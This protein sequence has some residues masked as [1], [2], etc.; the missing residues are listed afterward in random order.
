MQGADWLCLGALELAAA[1]LSAQIPLQWL[2]A[3]APSDLLKVFANER[4]ALAFV[5]L[6]HRSHVE[7]YRLRSPS[8]K[9]RSG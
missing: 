2:A 6:R 5:P 1:L 3:I 4:K 8:A 7:R 9:G